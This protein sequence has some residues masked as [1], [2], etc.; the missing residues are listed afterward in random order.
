MNL[1][2]ERGHLAREAHNAGYVLHR[3]VSFARMMDEAPPA[4]WSLDDLDDLAATLQDWAAEVSSSAG[5]RVLAEDLAVRTQRQRRWRRVRAE[6]DRQ[7]RNREGATPPAAP[8]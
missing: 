8:C 4:T 2:H 7:S 6:L 3:L 1:E 5:D